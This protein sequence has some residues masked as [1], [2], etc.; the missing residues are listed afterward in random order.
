MKDAKRNNSLGMSEVPLH[1]GQ[2]H[3]LSNLDRTNLPLRGE[4]VIFSPTDSEIHA[5]IKL[6]AEQRARESS[7]FG[8]K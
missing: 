3:L 1:D 2:R 7:C 4:V 5:R 6:L 8:G